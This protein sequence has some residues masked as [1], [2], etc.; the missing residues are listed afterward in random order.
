MLVATP[1]I[2]KLLLPPRQ[3]RGVSYATLVLAPNSFPS[4]WGVYYTVPRVPTTPPMGLY[5]KIFNWI[6]AEVDANCFDVITDWGAGFTTREHDIVPYQTWGVAKLLKRLSDDGCGTSNHL[7]DDY[8]DDPTQQ[9]CDTPSGGS[10]D[11]DEPTDPPADPP[12]PPD[13][14]THYD[15]YGSEETDESGNI[16]ITIDYC[17]EVP[18]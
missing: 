12:P 18:N 7:A 6:G 9:P 11:T 14:G 15:C 10:D 4:D 2:V 1:G 5:Q 8:T 13:S 17:V 16:Y 3:S